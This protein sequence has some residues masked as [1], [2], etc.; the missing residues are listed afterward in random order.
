MINGFE[1]QGNSIEILHYEYS[2]E[3]A[4]NGNPYNSSFQVKVASSKFVGI[5]ECEYDRKDWIR[6]IHDLEL[7]YD[8]K[9]EE[10]VFKDICYGSE[11][12]FVMDDTGHLKVS[13]MIYGCHMT[14]SMKFEFMAD[15]TVLPSFIS[16]LK[17]L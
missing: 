1:Y 3:D 16:Q 5:A 2:E 8:F 13:G 11:I 6:F 15:Q 14:H 4:N 7:L 10:V 9:I 17:R 12:S